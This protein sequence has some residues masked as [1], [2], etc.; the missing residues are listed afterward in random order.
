MLVCQL[1]DAARGGMDAHEELVERKRIA[2]GHD[3]LAVEHEP[4]RMGSL[5]RGYDF[6]EIPVERLT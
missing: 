2:L 3:E 5:E 6:G 4:L 1:G